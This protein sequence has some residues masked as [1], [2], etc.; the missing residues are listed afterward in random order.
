MKICSIY[1]CET[2]NT[3][4]VAYSIAS[5]FNA[6]LIKVCDT[7][8]YSR[9]T[10]FIVWCKMASGEEKTTIKPPSQEVSEYDPVAVTGIPPK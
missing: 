4:Q 2:G 7:T 9:L 5:A 6:H 3:P 8:S 1:Q 10:R